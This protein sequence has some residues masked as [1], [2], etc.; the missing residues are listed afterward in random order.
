MKHFLLFTVLMVL[1]T[2]AFSQYV[3]KAVVKDSSTHEPLQGVSVVIN[4]SGKGYVTDKEGKIIIPNLAAKPTQFTFSHTGYQPQTI[5]I[6]FAASNPDTSSFIQILLQAGEQEMEAVIVSSA[7]TNSRIENLPTR[8]EV[9]GAEEMQEENGIKPGNIASILGDIAGI[10]LQPT[11][12]TTGNADM[13]IQGLPG[14]YTQLLRDGLPL[15]G[16]YSG[17]FGIL[18]IPPLDL[19]QVEIIKGASSTLYGG[20]AIAGMINLISKKP[21]LN[22]PERSITINQ[23]TLNESNINTF[24]S[25]RM[26]KFGYTL[27][28]G[29][30]YQR[31]TDV[32]KDGFSDVPDLKSYFLHPRF[33][34]YPDSA[35]TITI[36]ITSNYEDREGGDMQAV[37]HSKDNQHQFFIQNKSFRNTLDAEWEHMLPQNDRLV[38][39]GTASFFNRNINSNTFGMKADQLSYYTEASYI[40]KLP[41]HD[42]VAGINITGENFHKHQPDSTLINNYT[43]I[44]PGVFIQ[45][46]WKLHPKWIVQG[47][48][49]YDHH[50]NYGSFVLPRL[51]ILYRI[52]NAFTT[53][54]GG[55]LGYKIPTVFSNDIDEREYPLLQPLQAVKAEKSSGANWDINFKTTVGSV[56]V[57]INQS[58]YL[59]QIN[60]PIV[61][62]TTNNEIVFHNQP[63]PILTRG[64]ESYVQVHYDKLEV[65]VGYVYTYAQKK[66]DAVQPYVSLSARN[67]FATVIAYEFSS[68]FRAGI[69]A[70]TTGKQYL[71]DGSTTPSYLFAA[72]MMRYNIGKFAFVLNCENLFDYRQTRQENIVIPPLAN[73]QF[74]QLWAPIDGRVVNLSVMMKW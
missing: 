11:S 72:A 19:K 37:L 12:A 20:G 5:E 68:R 8:V 60:H 21:R 35:N 57:T 50:N 61:Y 69:E 47:G 28:T 24:L 59:T 53:R 30:N 62:D 1:F 36:G 64:T 43:Y 65:Y 41:H 9:I 44:T 13:R 6:N 70:A 26:G 17:S 14:K 71:D 25:N 42:I 45:D 32:N 46:D 40:K 66:Y 33:F 48:L 27:F 22:Q 58:F 23:S 55:G 51:S 3:F 29:L 38:I 34:F 16:G 49:R 54:L 15:F 31:A 67:K 56:D 63:R 10:Q 18:Q 4:R 7:R 74:K 2:A 52:S 39:K 73:P